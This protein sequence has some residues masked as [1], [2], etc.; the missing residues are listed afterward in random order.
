MGESQYEAIEKVSKKTASKM[1][2]VLNEYQ[3]GTKTV[4]SEISGYKDQWR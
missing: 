2:G 3:T 1:L 4:S